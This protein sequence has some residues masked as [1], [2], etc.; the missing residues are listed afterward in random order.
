MFWSRLF[1]EENSH[2]FY[3]LQR[4][5]IS[6]LDVLNYISHG[7]S[8]LPGRRRRNPA[9]RPD[10]HPSAQDDEDEPRPVKN[11]LEAFA[12]N[13]VQRAKDGQIDPLIGRQNELERTI[14]VL[15]RRRKNNPIYVGDSG[16]GKTAIVDGLA[17]QIAKGEVP[18]VLK[19]ATIYSLDMGA[20]LAGTK[21]RGQFEERL[22]AVINELKKQP[23]CGAVY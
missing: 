9:S 12:S 17:L 8:K 22:K 4:Q 6:R 7:I 11:P 23:N 19:D 10:E 13:L 21:F 20:V 18:E 3:L 1:R 16:V 2:A 15:C 5:G 14:H